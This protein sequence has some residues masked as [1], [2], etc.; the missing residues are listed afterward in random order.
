MKNLKTL[1]TLISVIFLS[2]PVFAAGYK[3]APDGTYVGGDSYKLTPD[4][5]YIGR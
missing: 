2:S 4:G 5:T 1:I 3:L